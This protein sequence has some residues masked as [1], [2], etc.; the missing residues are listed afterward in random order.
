M[1]FEFNP[2]P[3]AAHFTVGTPHY[4]PL[5]ESHGLKPVSADLQIRRGPKQVKEIKMDATED[6][7]EAFRIITEKKPELKQ[8]RFIVDKDAIMREMTKPLFE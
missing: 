7:Q 8:H 3:G 2:A 4:S 6:Y 5:H 1:S